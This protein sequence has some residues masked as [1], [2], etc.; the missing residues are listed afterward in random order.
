MDYT[1]SP[2]SLPA[3]DAQQVAKK[4]EK[5]EMP[6]EYK[7]LMNPA[8]ISL[9]ADTSGKVKKLSDG[10][11]KAASKEKVAAPKATSQEELAKEQS[12]NLRYS[13]I[14]QAALSYGAQM[15]LHWRY[16]QI[17]RIVESDYSAKLDEYVSFRPFIDQQ[18]ILVPSVYVSNGTENYESSQKMVT[19]K[20]S[21]TVGEE[22]KIVSTAPTYRNY[23][24][25]DFPLP[26][27]LHPALIPKSDEEIIVWRK[28]AKIGW[29][30]GVMQADNV[31]DD[32]RHR[33]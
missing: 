1:T 32:G 14:E 10:E 6:N 20:I 31:Y 26:R 12:N 16:E 21:F 2:D 29:N 33:L 17:N 23:L 19:T 25:R 27:K 5:V 11:I 28:A 18:N 15:G 3:P 4:I 9:G 7:V 8:S 30:M 13:A 24:I 22:A